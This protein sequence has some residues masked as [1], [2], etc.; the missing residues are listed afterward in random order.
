MLGEQYPVGH[1]MR[2][3]ELGG[4]A[5]YC[6]CIPDDWYHVCIYIRAI[7]DTLSAFIRSCD[8]LTRPYAFG[9]ESET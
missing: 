7:D 2:H 6:I 3:K 4:E 9:I 5:I 1:S 8:N